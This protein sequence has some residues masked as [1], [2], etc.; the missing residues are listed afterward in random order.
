ME[1]QKKIGVAVLACGG[2]SR[3]VV[4]NLLR[5]SNRQI[6]ILSVYDPIDS[7]IDKAFEEWQIDGANTLRATSAEEAINTPGVEWV[8]VFSP[9]AYHK[10]H[11]LA[12]FKAGKH[13]FSEKP[14]GNLQF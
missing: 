1:N 11:I 4:K 12:A 10:E 3:Y 8:M 14:L 6:Q 9:N 7:I 5:D 2:R 13:V